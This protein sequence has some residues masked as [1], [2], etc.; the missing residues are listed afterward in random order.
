MMK[1]ENILTIEELLLLQGGS[2][3]QNGALVAVKKGH[4]DLISDTSPP[5]D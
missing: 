1:K 5:H 2:L 4:W 3:E